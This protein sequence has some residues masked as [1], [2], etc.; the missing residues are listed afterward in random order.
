[1]QR[2]VPSQ[3]L[4]A[5]ID[6][7][8]NSPRPWRPAR[9]ADVV[10]GVSCAP[11]S[12]EAARRPRASRPSNI[13]KG[14][15]RPFCRCARSSTSS[16]SLRIEKTAF[17]AAE[18]PRVPASARSGPRRRRSWSSASK[19][20]SASTGRYVICAARGFEVLVPVDAGRVAARRGSRR[21][22]GAL[23]ARGCHHHQRRDHRLRLA[24]QGRER[25]FPRYLQARA[26]R[27]RGPAYRVR[28]AKAA[29]R[30][31]V[32][33]QMGLQ[34]RSIHTARSLRAGCL[35]TPGVETQCASASRPNAMSGL[36]PG[37]D[38]G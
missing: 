31:S 14:S 17:S 33:P 13:P 11:R 6:I 10:R 24:R 34:I 16:A 26:V 38:R 32:E 28:P 1:M 18:V 21:R 35:A 7:K 2:L 9:M 20:A 37:R 19:F 36:S 30:L 8:M 22:L 25:R 12:S 5:V 4:V 27:I 29:C 3:T 15:S 23:R